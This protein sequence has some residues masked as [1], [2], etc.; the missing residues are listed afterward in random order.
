MK[1]LFIFL[2]STFCVN[3]LWANKEISLLKD[4]LIFKVAGEV[5]TENDLKKFYDLAED[6]RCVYPDSLT[7]KLFD[8]FFSKESKKYYGKYDKQLSLEQRKYFLK[9]LE[10]SKV[11]VYRQSYTVKLENSLLTY[12]KHIGLKKKCFQ[13]IAKNKNTFSNRHI[14]FFKLEIFLRDRFLPVEIQR[15][16]TGDE[17]VKAITSAK[18]FLKSIS[19]QLDQEVYWPLK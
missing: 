19:D 5:F 6:I 14:E 2:I 3:T 13:K 18:N 1:L 12:L 16:S 8:G 11:Y 17:M 9:A 10:F 7:L 15:E 4:R